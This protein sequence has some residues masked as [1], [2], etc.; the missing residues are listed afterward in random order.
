VTV[1][2]RAPGRG[3]AAGADTRSGAATADSRA[4][5]SLIAVLL[6]AA[7]ALDLTRCGLVL[8]TVRHPAPATGLVAAGLAAA[9]FSSW[10]AR[11]CLARWRWPPWAALVIG[12][13]SAPQAAASGFA[14][15]YTVPDA[16][17][18]ALGILLAV[19]VLATAGGT[20]VAQQTEDSCAVGNPASRD[21]GA[22][23][24]PIGGSTEG[25]P[26][27]YADRRTAELEGC[28]QPAI[29]VH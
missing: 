6:L 13:A 18:A 23:R 15:P 10:T 28:E 21:S 24:P 29:R 12:A 19:A 27:A 8:A 11:G 25:L 1:T 17:T 9:A 5:R 7:A 26:R 20:G 16:A 22:I 2:G 14:A 3:L 4:A